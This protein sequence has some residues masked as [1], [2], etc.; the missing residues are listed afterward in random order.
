MI[1]LSFSKCV[2]EIALGKVDPSKVTK[3]ISRTACKTSE[4]WQ[5]TIEVYASCGY[6]ETCFA[7]SE[8]QDT[9]EELS[10]FIQKCKEVAHK[11]IPLV[12]QPKSTEGRFPY[13]SNIFWVESE[14]EIKW[15]QW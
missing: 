8:L 9:E 2:A 11:M 14:S 7:L 10:K 1:G 5:K 15:I 13:A 12:H 6:W 4:D 3:I